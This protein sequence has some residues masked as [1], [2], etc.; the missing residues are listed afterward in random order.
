MPGAGS[1]PFGGSAGG[2]M[3]LT[4]FDV[5]SYEGL[6]MGTLLAE[7]FITVVGDALHVYADGSSHVVLKGDAAQSEIYV[8][9]PI[10]EQYTVEWSVKFVSLPSDFTKL[11]TD[12]LFIG[13]ID[14]GGVAAGFYFSRA[15]IAYTPCLGGGVQFLPGSQL[16]INEDEY[17]TFRLAVDRLSGNVYFYITPTADVGRIG[18]QLKFVLP[19]IPVARCPVPVVEGILLAGMGVTR[20]VEMDFASLALATAFIVPNLRPIA[21]AGTDQAVRT[22]SVIKLDGRK[23][24]DPE[25]A[26]LSY[27][28]RI[29]DA[30]ENSQYVFSNLDGETPA[31]ASAPGAL[32]TEK[33]YSPSFNGLTLDVGTVLVVRGVAYPVSGT[34]LD[35]NGYYVRVERP[36]L[37]VGMED[38]AYKLI[39][40]NGLT[41]HLTATPR[42]YPDVPGFFKFDLIVYDGELVS[43]ISTTVAN[44]LA[45][46]IP[47]G[48]IPNLSF[49]WDYLSNFWSLVENKQRIDT[50]WSAAAQIIAS[51][52]LNLWQIDY[53]KSLRDIQRSVQRRWLH[54]PLRVDETQVEL[55]TLRVLDEQLDSI[56]IADSDPIGGTFTVNWPGGSKTIT[57]SVGTTASVH[58][59]VRTALTTAPVSVV[60]YDDRVTSK[61]V[62]RL[63]GLGLE[64]TESS[65]TLFPTGELSVPTA[66][67]SGAFPVK[68]K[69]FRVSQSLLGIG[70]AEDD[71]LVNGDTLYR[72]VRIIDDPADD[73]SWSRVVVKEDI[74]VDAPA[75]WAVVSRVNSTQIDFWE[76]LFTEGDKATFE[77]VDLETDSL[78]YLT[79][80]V[81]GV[82]SGLPNG[83]AVD[84][85]SLYEYIAQPTKYDVFLS[86]VHHLVHIP[87]DDLVVDV[88]LLQEK[89]V[90]PS[91]TS[92]LH[93]NVDFYL[94]GFRGRNSLRF[95]PL[96]WDDG[97]YP[98][99]LWAEYT[100]LDNR[101][102]IEANFGIPAEFTL[103][104]LEVVGANLDYLSAVRGLWYAYLNGP[105][106][107]NLKIGTQI[108]LG[109]PYAEE[110]GTIE[111]IRTDFSPTQGRILIRDRDATEVVRSYYFPVSL[112]LATNPATGAVYAPG[113]SVELFA[114]LVA[115]VEVLD[116]E[117]KEDWF[118]GYL[119]QGVFLEVEKF[120]KFMV[121]VDSAVFNLSSLL[122]AKSFVQ[123]IK[124][125]ATYGIFVV[126][127]E[128]EASEINVTDVITSRVHID[129]FDG[130]WTN[131]LGEVT[132]FDDPRAGGNSTTDGGDRWRN[133]FDEDNNPD[134][135]PPT[136]PTPDTVTWAF[137]Q[138]ALSPAEY[139]TVT[140]CEDF[141]GTDPLTGLP[142]GDPFFPP[143]ESIFAFDSPVY[144]ESDT[145]FSTPIDWS[146]DTTLAADV[147]CARLVI[148]S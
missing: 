137:D 144:L 135:S 22:C 75:D 106:V 88:P 37:P 53:S 39:Y 140:A 94:E 76:E 26:V 44:V 62:I 143:F 103:D 6:A 14:V 19:A 4:S 46:A 35:V 83:L 52:L 128:V 86:R 84:L 38:E 11:A 97:V 5:F 10:A 78:T 57:V 134:D 32:F 54:Y 98:D 70:I 68:P 119:S 115:G 36:E 23:S 136:P 27:G 109:L 15:G 93:R 12:F 50:F 85:S 116:Y 21:D 141:T 28:W 1:I 42:F 18:H 20:P 80:D 118:A 58:L 34:G 121:R 61:K 65:S 100:Y 99:R 131:P 91:E 133:H 127:K 112:D 69:T 25:G 33:F 123:R 79:C 104:D 114:P 67:G 55:T 77:V 117:S 17:L 51:D 125:T 41:D 48:V 60:L 31:A 90:S 30:P 147:Y 124:P 142:W 24:F 102:Q 108:L 3:P 7:P 111:E 113:D 74:P 82:C 146:F 138:D 45:S 63:I 47:R 122:F 87:V 43:E 129:L 148:V 56:Q 8:D 95:D 130:T 120:W 29:V 71:L 96:V 139:I 105:T 132:M 89:I 59:A 126:L 49:F 9:Q 145:T 2:S 64:I 107:E 66:S 13:A 101:P 40:Q 110:R 73:L 16:S 92:I 72:I 81:L